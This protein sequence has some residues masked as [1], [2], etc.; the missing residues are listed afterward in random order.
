[1]LF[2]NCCRF[3]FASPYAPINIRRSAEGK[4]LDAS[5]VISRALQQ[6]VSRL[7]DL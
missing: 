4:T 1:V 2:T 3:R 7:A 5:S 6:N